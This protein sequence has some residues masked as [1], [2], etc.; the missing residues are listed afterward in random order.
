MPRLPEG[1]DPRRPGG[2]LR[3]VSG[4]PEPAAEGRGWA[5]ARR[6]DPGAAR[7]GAEEAAGGRVMNR[8]VTPVK[9]KQSPKRQGAKP[10][11]AK[12]EAKRPVARKS[13]KRQSARVGHLEKRLAEALKPEAQDLAQQTAQRQ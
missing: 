1:A 8:R 12:V 3:P 4:R 2:L 9:G 11:K 7:G 13:R 5:G 6:G 10:A